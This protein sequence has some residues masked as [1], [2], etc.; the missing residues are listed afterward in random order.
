MIYIYT[1]CLQAIEDANQESMDEESSKYGEFGSE[2][3]AGQEEDDRNVICQIEQDLLF[4]LFF[5]ET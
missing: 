1:Y 2:D 5:A 4:Y 3:C